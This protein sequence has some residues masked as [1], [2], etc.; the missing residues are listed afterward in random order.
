MHGLGAFLAFVG[1]SILSVIRFL[2]EQSPV[3]IGLLLAVVA[4]FGMLE[5][6]GAVGGWTAL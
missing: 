2:D 3:L 6:A 4:F 5:P 1:E